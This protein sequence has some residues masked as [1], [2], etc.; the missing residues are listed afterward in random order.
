MARG[1]E[2]KSVETQIETSTA[3]GSNNTKGRLSPE[4]IDLL[5]KKE[6]LLLSRARVLHDLE[7]TRNPRYRDMLE[8]ALRHLERELA[9]IALRM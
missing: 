4:Q 1:W 7:A 3:E 2:S 6:G 8:E 5:R 9:G